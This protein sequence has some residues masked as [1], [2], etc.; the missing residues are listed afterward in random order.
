MM[1]GPIPPG[2]FVLLIIWLSAIGWA[3]SKFGP[4]GTAIALL[5]LPLL[6]LVLSIRAAMRGER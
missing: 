5:S 4:L 6:G 3:G 1:L 2:A